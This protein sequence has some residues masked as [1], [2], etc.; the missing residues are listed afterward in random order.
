MTQAGT[1]RRRTLFLSFAG[2]GVFGC[3][4][5]ATQPMTKVAVSTGHPPIGLIVWQLAFTAGCLGLIVA[6]RRMK[7]GLTRRHLFYYAVIGLLGTIL[8]DMF[9]YLAA[10][11]LPAG[12][13]SIALATVPIFSFGIALAAGNESF[14]PH[15]VMGIVLGV[16][17]MMMIAVPD[18]S[19]P[20]PGMAPWIFVAL[21]AP[22]CYGLEGN[23]IGRLAPDDVSPVA[24]LFAASVFGLMVAAPLAWYSGDLIDLTQPW[25]DAEWA[26]FA[27]SVAHAAAYAGYMWLVGVAG[28]VFSSQISYV[29]MASAVGLSMIFL[30][31]AYSVWVWLA[32]GLMGFGLTLVQPVGK[33]PKP[34]A[35]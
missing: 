16:A 8:P 17:A 35:A 7:I 23:F 14:R 5:G 32:I 30:G 2:L 24:V 13:L 22:V 34:V 10:A 11:H 31:E 29:V 26:L 12:I 20:D 3:I 33:L 4:W 1:P 18:A 27:S 25:G 19:L 28:V 15:R 9:V 21:V 6:I